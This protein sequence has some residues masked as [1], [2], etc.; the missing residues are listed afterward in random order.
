[1]NPLVR[2]QPLFRFDLLPTDVALN[3]WLLV[4]E[5][6]TLEVVGLA[7]RLRAEVALVVADRAVFGHIVSVKRLFLKVMFG[8]N[9]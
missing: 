2:N 4:T 1:M 7:E 8:E 5:H 6:V 3:L 9:S